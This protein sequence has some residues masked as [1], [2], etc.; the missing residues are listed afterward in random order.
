M[1]QLCYL[2][3]ATCVFF[4]YAV[5][6][7]TSDLLYHYKNVVQCNYMRGGLGLGGITARLPWKGSCALHEYAQ[8]ILH[9]ICVLG[10]QKI[11]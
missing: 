11:K 5:V 9:R 4:D 7:R 10:C 6:D 8:E 2:S 3:V 1:D